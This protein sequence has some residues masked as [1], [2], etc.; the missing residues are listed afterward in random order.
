M[1]SGRGIIEKLNV[2]GGEVQFIWHPFPGASTLDIKNHIRRYLNGQNPESFEDRTK[3]G[4]TETNTR[5][6]N[7]TKE[8]TATP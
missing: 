2:A 1:W 3:K 4:N 5:S 8:E 6:Y 7:P